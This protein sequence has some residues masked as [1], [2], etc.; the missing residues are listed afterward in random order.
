MN[1][2]SICLERLRKDIRHIQL[3][4]GVSSI[5]IVGSVARNENKQS[6]DI[7]LLVSFMEIPS[8]FLLG[9]LRHNLYEILRMEVDL[10]VDEGLDTDF[11]NRIM[12]EGVKV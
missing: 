9:D 4:Y 8:L 11:R 6:S 7:D 2:L 3:S 12:E 10:I 5:H 1:T